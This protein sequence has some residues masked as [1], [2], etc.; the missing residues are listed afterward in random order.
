MKHYKHKEDRLKMACYC[1]RYQYWG[2]Y[3]YVVGEPFDNTCPL[4]YYVMRRYINKPFTQ[5]A[6]SPHS[7]HSTC[8]N[9]NQK[10]YV[11]PHGVFLISIL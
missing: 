5:L 8:D 6:R 7:P 4:L 10:E 11:I 9:F 3:V 1:V 2:F